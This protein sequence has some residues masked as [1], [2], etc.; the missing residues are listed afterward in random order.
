MGQKSSKSQGKCQTS[1]YTRARKRTAAS[2]P[3]TTAKGGRTKR[4]PA[5]SP[6]PSQNEGSEVLQPSNSDASS[7]DVQDAMQ[8]EMRGADEQN[9]STIFM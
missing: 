9:V 3:A 7:G 5:P 4:R 6:S 1:A 2:Q 8:Q